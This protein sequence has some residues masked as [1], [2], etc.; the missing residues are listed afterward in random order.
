MWLWPLGDD[1]PID[2]TRISLFVDRLRTCSEGALFLPPAY[3]TWPA[4]GPFR[5]GDVED[6]V[7]RFP[8]PISA[9]PHM[10]SAVLRLDYAR[11]VGC[12]ARWI[13]LLHVQV[14]VLLRCVSAAG[15]AVLDCRVLISEEGQGPPRWPAI[16]AYL[17]AWETLRG[18]VPSSV[19]GLVD[20]QESGSRTPAIVGAAMYDLLGL[21]VQ[22]FSWGHAVRLVRLVQLREAWRVFLLGA[23]LLGWAWPR[24]VAWTLVSLLSALRRHRALSKLCLLTGADSNRSLISLISKAL[25]VRRRRLSDRASSDY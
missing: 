3:L 11:Q 4:S 17:G 14:P 25:T 20:R 9:L 2:F 1:E 19:V 24:P 5:F 15:L 10:S 21:Q 18:S 16:E 8:V 23:V 6:L 7:R 12:L 22:G 13:G